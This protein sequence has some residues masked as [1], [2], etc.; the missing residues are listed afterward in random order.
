MENGVPTV[1]AGI[2]SSTVVYS[3]ILGIVTAPG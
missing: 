1:T 2:A 3:L